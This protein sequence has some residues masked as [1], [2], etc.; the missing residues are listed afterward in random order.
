MNKSFCFMRFA[1][2]YARLRVGVCAA[3]VLQAQR[4]LNMLIMVFLVAIKS[5]L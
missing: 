3:N 1:I 5:Q 2:V 4:W